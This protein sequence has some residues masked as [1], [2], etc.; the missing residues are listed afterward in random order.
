MSV[1]LSYMGSLQISTRKVKLDPK[2]EEQKR[3]RVS[4][5][6]YGRRDEVP[7]DCEMALRKVTPHS[8]GYSHN[9]R[10]V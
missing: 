6:N 8:G 3:P 9:V 1:L 7:G 5:G 2:T 4:W 10:A